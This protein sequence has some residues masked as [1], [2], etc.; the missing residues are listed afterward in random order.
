MSSKAT[1]IEKTESQ[2][3][4]TQHGTGEASIQELF[5]TQK[6]NFAT[7]VTKTCKWRIEQLD[8]LTRML[9]D[10]YKRFADASCKDFKTAV[11]ENVFEVSA[12]IATTEFTKSQ[13][14]EWMKPVEAPIPKFLAATG[15]KGIVYRE[16]YGV[17]LIICPLNGPLLLSLRPAAAAL[18]AGNSCILKLSEAL[19]AT[20]ELL[21]ELI[22]KYFEPEVLTAV[23][24]GREIVTELLEL[25]FDFIFLTGS[26]A[27]GKAVMKAAA[28]HLTP[29]LLELGG[30]NP[31]IVD[32]TANLPDAAKKIVWGAMAWG[33]QW[34]TSPGYAAIHE[35]VAEAFVVECKKAVVDLYGTDPKSNSDYSRVISPAAVKR[36][37]S[38]IDP[39]KVVSGGKFDESAP[40][41]DPTI[42]YPVSWSDKVMEDEVFGPLLPIL[43]YSD[44]GK[45]LAKIKSLPKPLAGYVFSRNQR[46]IDQVL[47]SLSFGGGAVNQTNIFLWIETMPYGGVGTSGIGNYY[48]KYGFDSLTHAKSILVSPP[49]VA[50]DHLFP[51]YTKEKV[52]A[53]NQW[54]DY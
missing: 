10:N 50:I 16:P 47:G 41:L 52:Q 42:L 13:L 49:D 54:F 4:S 15:H 24:G 2:A 27:A 8:R 40:Y 32:E 22:P 39:S 20:N 12:S 14:K 34:C 36:L 1:I 43:T 28:E 7:D 9:K 25:P 45:L 11:Q 5:D 30:Q 31:A 23:V 26:V 46:T 37:A 3:N 38:L 33:G 51:P 18:S 35:S 29:V 48:G 53:L 19:P 44:L 21:L 17:T 6:A